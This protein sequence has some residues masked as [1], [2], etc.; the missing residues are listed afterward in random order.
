MLSTEHSENRIIAGFENEVGLGMPQSSIQ[1]TYN[2]QII[3]MIRI[4]M[5]HNQLHMVCALGIL[6]GLVIDEHWTRALQL[7]SRF[8]TAQNT[9][10]MC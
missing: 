1:Q 5:T 4:E 3:Y 6:A 7:W 8:H 10:L 9:P 2:R